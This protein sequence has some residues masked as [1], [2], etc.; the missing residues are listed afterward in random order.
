MVNEYCIAKF[1]V[2]AEFQVFLIRNIIKF[3]KSNLYFIQIHLDPI[4]HTKMRLNK[5][6][7]WICFFLQN[8]NHL[9][10]TRRFK[11]KLI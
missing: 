3:T 8:S 5:F 9:K 10:S 2:I 6:Q 1:K 7:K 11:A 4:N